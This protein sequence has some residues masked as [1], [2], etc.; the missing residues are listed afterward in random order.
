MLDQILKK[1]CPEGPLF[2]QACV[3]RT[4]VSYY[5]QF[6]FCFKIQYIW[7]LTEC[8]WFE[9]LTLQ[10]IEWQSL[11]ADV[12]VHRE[13]AATAAR[14]GAHGVSRVRVGIHVWSNRVGRDT[15]RLQHGVE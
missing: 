12:R 9:E 7:R 14:H 11:K 6:T 5:A 4:L 10:V 2:V 8:R 13:P 15:P 3:K 1:V